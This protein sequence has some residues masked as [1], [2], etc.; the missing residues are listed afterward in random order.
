MF[1]SNGGRYVCDERGNVICNNGW[2]GNDTHCTTPVCFP[3]NKGKRMITAL[4]NML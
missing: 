3:A 2:K 4:K 1:K